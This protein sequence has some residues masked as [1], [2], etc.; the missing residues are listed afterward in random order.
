MKS[1]EITMA[2]RKL[3][4]NLPSS[5]EALHELMFFLLQRGFISEKDAQTIEQQE[6]TAKASKKKSRCE[7][8]AD[9]I[10][11]KAPLKGKSKEFLNLVREFR[12]NFS[13]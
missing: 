3:T 9:E 1:K 8:F 10:H 4:I 12:E 11:Q 6:K 13:L 7:Q 5:P 2:Q